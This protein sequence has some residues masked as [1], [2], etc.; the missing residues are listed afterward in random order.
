MRHEMPQSYEGLGQFFTRGQSTAS[1][2]GPVPN[3]SGR[4]LSKE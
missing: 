3:W 2:A 4:S 1:M